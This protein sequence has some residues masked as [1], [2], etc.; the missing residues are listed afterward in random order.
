MRFSARSVSSLPSG[1]CS[2]PPLRQRVVTVH[3]DINLIESLTVAENVLLNNEPKIAPFGLL[4]GRAMRETTA[5]LLDSYCIEVDPA[6]LVA[7]LPNDV[8]AVGKTYMI[9]AHCI[10]GGFPGIATGDLTNRTLPYSVGY[11]DAGIFQVMAQ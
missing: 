6:A 9:R 5:A 3:Q 1:Y 4:R 8:F 7:T 10:V 2:T 11:L